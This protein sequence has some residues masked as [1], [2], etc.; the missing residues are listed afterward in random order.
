MIWKSVVLL[1]QIPFYCASEY[2]SFIASFQ[3][4]GHWSEKEYLEYRDSIPESKVFTVCHWEKTQFFSERA[5]AIWAYC[6]QNS[7]NDL[8]LRCIEALYVTPN[9]KGDIKFVV[10]EQE[11][12]LFISRKWVMPYR[13]RHWNHFCWVH[14]NDSNEIELYHNG[15]KIQI[16]QSYQISDSEHDEFKPFNINIQ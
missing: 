15:K 10:M 3:Y 14:P 16:Y 6:R 4:S 12:K 5:N 8:T 9:E 7:E 2:S 1:L 13:H 11:G